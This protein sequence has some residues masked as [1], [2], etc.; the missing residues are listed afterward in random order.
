MLG[1]EIGDTVAIIRSGEVIPKIL[2]KVEAW[3]N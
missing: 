1:I 2:H 3:W